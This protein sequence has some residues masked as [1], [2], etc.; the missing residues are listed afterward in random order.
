M[1]PPLDLG[2]VIRPNPSN[3]PPRLRLEGGGFKVI[4][5]TEFHYSCTLGI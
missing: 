4:R 5:I 1:I 2:F 3:T